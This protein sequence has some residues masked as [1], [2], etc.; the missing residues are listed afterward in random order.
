ML[1]AP[2]ATRNK[3]PILQVLRQYFDP[4]IEYKV[5][6]IASGTGEHVTYFAEHMPNITFQ[7]S[8][9]NP[10]YLHSIVAHVDNF[11]LP[12]VRVPLC[13]DVRKPPD[14]WAL[15]KD[16]GPG[17]LDAVLNFNMIHISSNE[18][19]H[20]IFRAASG[21]LKPS[22]GLL[23]TYG[24]YAI[25]GGIM[26][27]REVTELEKLANTNDMKLSKIHEMPANNHMLIFKKN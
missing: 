13:I 18:A 2:A 24:P 25:N 10:R 1:S 20:G 27:L 14:V 15:P 5:L 22:N 6:E 16:A 21:L 12:N 7:P 19:I 23:I 8:E 11:R 3:E 26:G 4:N 17:E 9:L